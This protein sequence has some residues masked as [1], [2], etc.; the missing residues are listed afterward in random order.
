MK[1]A[2]MMPY[3][4]NA[5]HVSTNGLPLVNPSHRQLVKDTGLSIAAVNR[6]ITF[7]TTGENSP[8]NKY[9]IPWG[10]NSRAPTVYELR[11][12]SNDQ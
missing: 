7:L 2:M 5:S 6:A 10:N 9:W 4:I 11:P 3:Y 8:L 1:V 12:W